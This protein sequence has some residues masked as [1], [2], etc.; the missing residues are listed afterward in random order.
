MIVPFVEQTS[1]RNICCNNDV[2]QYKQ[3]VGILTK[4]EGSWACLYMS[5]A[6]FCH[7]EVWD[8]ED[9]NSLEIKGRF[10][11]WDLGYW[12]GPA[13]MY[14][15]LFLVIF[16]PNASSSVSSLSSVVNLA[17][18]IEIWRYVVPKHL[19]TQFLFFCRIHYVNPFCRRCIFAYKSP[20][21]LLKKP[22]L[23]WRSCI[24][25]QG[26]PNWPALFHCGRWSI[27]VNSWS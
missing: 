20:I 5:V 17:W 13:H 9:K 27:V 23:L 6:N 24:H 18:V 4:R 11:S 8:G 22:A 26:Q 21:W 2:Q 25:T 19:Y 12:F 1:G 7:R 10:V 3:N 15:H 16:Q 14:F